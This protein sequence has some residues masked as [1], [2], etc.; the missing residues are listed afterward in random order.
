[1]N[2][3]SIPFNSLDK[4]DGA[5]FIKNNQN[6]GVWRHKTFFHSYGEALIAKSDLKSY[7]KRHGYS[8]PRF[9]IRS[10][11]KWTLEKINS[12]IFQ[13]MNPTLDVQSMSYDDKIALVVSFI[14]SKKELPLLLSDYVV[15]Y[16]Y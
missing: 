15:L 3:H 2:K 12:C 9:R 5:K 10:R 13:W 8:I 1:M 4:L 14:K 16:V 6:N 11:G 7:A